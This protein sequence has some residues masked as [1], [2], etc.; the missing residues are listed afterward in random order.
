MDEIY[1]QTD[2]DCNI[3]AKD[4]KMILV[5]A[6]SG[7]HDAGNFAQI[8]INDEPVI[9]PEAAKNQYGRGLHMVFINPANGKVELARIFDTNTSSE[10]FDWYRA[11]NNI[12]DGFIVVAACKDDAQYNLSHY[13]KHFFNECGS[14][15]IWDLEYRESFAFIGVKGEL[16]KGLEKKGKTRKE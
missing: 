11:Y 3:P 7:G 9:I 8:K 5:Q 15:I 4:K 13:T 12:P 2:Q 16:R 10:E 14:L 6:F 1:L